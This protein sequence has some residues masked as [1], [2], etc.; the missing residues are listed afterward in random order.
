MMQTYNGRVE[1]GRF[2]PLDGTSV[3]DCKTAVLILEGVP[4]DISRRQ[5]EAMRRF[6]KEIN[7]AQKEEKQEAVAWLEEFHRLL[8][9]ADTQLREE[10]FPRMRFERELITFDD[11]E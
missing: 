2:Y 4:R 6:H 8:A 1:A 10:D 3:P 5:A 7:V 11:G 9:T